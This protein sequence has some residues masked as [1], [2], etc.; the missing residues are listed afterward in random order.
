MRV[1]YT[2]PVVEGIYCT[3]TGG[4]RFESRLGH[5][6]LWDFSRFSQSLQT[7]ARIILRSDNDRFLPYPFHFVIYLSSHRWTLLLYLLYRRFGTA[8]P[9]VVYHV[10]QPEV[11]RYSICTGLYWPPDNGGCL[12]LTLGNLAQPTDGSHK[13]LLSQAV[14][15][16]RVAVGMWRCGPVVCA[17]AR[18][19]SHYS[20][21]CFR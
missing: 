2:S 13:G 7:N 19:A 3:H 4:A 10:S 11:G 12:G 1:A 17:V 15:Q 9:E 5:Q 18:C 20:S 8:V 21:H 14:R 6:I 16:S